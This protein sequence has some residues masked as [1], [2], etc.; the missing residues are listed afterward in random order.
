MR[1]LLT[2]A[3]S[4]AC[5]TA[6][7]VASGQKPAA[8][9]NVVLIIA[10]DLGLD[11]GCYGNKVIRTPNLD[12]LAKKGVRFTRAYATVSSCSVSHAVD[13]APDI[14]RRRLPS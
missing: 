2:L 14:A 12:A 7:A 4:L 10:D 8:P 13:A 1:W 6:P 9:R 3:L 5:F 11:L